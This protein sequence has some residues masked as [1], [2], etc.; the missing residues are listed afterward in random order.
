MQRAV[1]PHT[2]AL[3]HLAGIGAVIPG[4]VLQQHIINAEQERAAAAGDVGEFHGRDLRRGF[5]FD[6][7]AHS[8]F[9]DVADDVFGCVINAA[10]LADFGL[11]HHARGIGNDL[12]EKAFVNAPQNVNGD[13][14]EIVGRGRVSQF[15]ADAGE[16]FSV[17]LKPRRVELRVLLIDDAVVFAIQPERGGNEIFP[18]TVL[19]AEVFDL[20]RLNALVFQKAREDETIQCALR[21]FGKIITV[22]VGIGFLERRRKLLPVGVEF[23]QKFIVG[24]GVAAFEQAAPEFF[25][26]GRR[27]GLGEFLQ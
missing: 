5:A 3:F 23:F 12:A 18:D 27:A 19:L 9:H 24:V 14:V 20:R 15:L 26:S 7:F 2:V 1:A 8:V 11:F 13:G 6:H 17:R 16:N 22:E 4:V 10:R 25:A 21:D